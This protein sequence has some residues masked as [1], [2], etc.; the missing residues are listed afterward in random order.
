MTET[1]YCLMGLDGKRNLADGIGIYLKVG[2]NRKLRRIVVTPTYA[3]S[4][5]E[6][7]IHEARVF[8]RMEREK[9]SD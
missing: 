3:L 8:H 2:K 6:E 4:L 7:L 5:A 9:P 1:Q